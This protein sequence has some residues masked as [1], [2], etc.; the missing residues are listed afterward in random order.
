MSR[1]GTTLILS[2]FFFCLG[3]DETLELEILGVKSDT[4][5][6][7]GYRGRGTRGLGLGCGKVSVST[8]GWGFSN[9]LLRTRAAMFLRDGSL[10]GKVSKNR[11]PELVFRQ[12]WDVPLGVCEIRGPK[13]LLRLNVT[14]E[15]CSRT[16]GS[17][18]HPPRRQEDWDWT[19]PST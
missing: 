3:R 9:T 14:S 1:S 16:G 2:L 7:G 4:N 13:R 8:Q 12:G 5:K 11:I 15:G 19:C 10:S 17:P 18:R 6:T